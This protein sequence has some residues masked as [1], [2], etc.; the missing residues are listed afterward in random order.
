MSDVY[1]HVYLSETGGHLFCISRSFF[2]RI[3]AASFLDF[4]QLLFQIFRLSTNIAHV[5]TPGNICRA[6]RASCEAFLEKFEADAW[7]FFRVLWSV[8]T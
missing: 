5:V 4:S 2:L 6:K 1:V 8:G 7:F 3:F